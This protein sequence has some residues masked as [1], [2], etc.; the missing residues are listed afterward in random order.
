MKKRLVALLLAGATI[1]GAITGC[2][3]NAETASEPMAESA[4]YCYE[5]TEAECYEEPAIEYQKEDSAI[6]YAA[7]KKAVYATHN[8]YLKLNETLTY[9]YIS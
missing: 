1:S 9:P 4:T 8:E 2:G 7:E 5:E 6:N 3:I